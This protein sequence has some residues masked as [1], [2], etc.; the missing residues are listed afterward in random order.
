MC[1]T[2]EFAKGDKNYDNAYPAQ[3]VRSGGPGRVGVEEY[4]AELCCA[5]GS[6]VEAAFLRRGYGFLEGMRRRLLILNFA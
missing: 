2:L 5:E 6:T 1:L 3:T 4:P